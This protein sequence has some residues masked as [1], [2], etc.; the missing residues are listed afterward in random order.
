[1]RSFARILLGAFLVLRS[2]AATSPIYTF[3]PS[4]KEG[5]GCQV[6]VAPDP[7][8]PGRVIAGGDCWFFHRT[9]NYGREWTPSA[10]RDASDT[11]RLF[12]S[13]NDLSAAA[14]RFSLKTSN[15]VYAGIGVITGSGGFLRSTNAGGT[16]VEVSTVPRFVGDNDAAPLVAQG[17]PRSVGNLIALDPTG[18]CDSF[19]RRRHRHRYAELSGSHPQTIRRRGP[20]PCRPQR[21]RDLRRHVQGAVFDEPGP[22]FDGV[23]VLVTQAFDNNGNYAW[24]NNLEVSAPGRF[25]RLGEP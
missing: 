22:A 3:A 18:T 21:Y 8:T 23:G 6:S 15:L 17:H 1:M 19:V 9:T 4:G 7:F 2:L 11:Q 14:V 25:F 16:W 13:M 24:T 10:V 5:G 20:N 12:D